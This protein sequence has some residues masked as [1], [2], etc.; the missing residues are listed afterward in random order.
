MR[1]SDDE[2]PILCLAWSACCTHGKG[3]TAQHAP[4]PSTTS[5]ACLPAL[6]LPGAPVTVPPVP[7]PAPGLGG[8]SNT[9]WPLPRRGCISHT[10]H[11][12]TPSPSLS[13]AA[14]TTRRRRGWRPAAP[15]VPLVAV[16]LVSRWKFRCGS[17]MT[18]WL[19]GWQAPRGAAAQVS[20]R[21][22]Q[23]SAAPPPWPPASATPPPC[24][25]PSRALTKAWPVPER[26]V[27]ERHTCGERPAGGGSGA[28][29]RRGAPRRRHHVPPGAAAA[30]AAPCLVLTY[31]LPELGE[32][33]DA[34]LLEEPIHGLEVL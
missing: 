26:P 14:A 23:P 34:F 3:W 7:C 17:V 27:R 25:P 6:P 16:S 9:L 10:D 29:R 15:E 22:C 5:P 12:H 2:I 13:S 4:C 30:A 1:N 20:R 8:A 24:P 28:A 11:R 31:L 33:E 32:Q 18:Q 21:T 19:A